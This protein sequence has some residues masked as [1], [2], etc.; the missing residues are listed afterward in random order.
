M[1]A[2][3]GEPGQRLRGLAVGVQLRRR[4]AAPGRPL[5]R[6]D[7]AA[8][9]RPAR[10]P[11][12]RVAALQPRVRR[13]AVGP[14]RSTRSP[15]SRRRSAATRATARPRAADPDFDPIRRE[16]GYPGLVRW[17]WSTS[18]PRMAEL[19]AKALTKDGY[20]A[21]FDAGEPLGD[22]PL[23]RRADD[24]KRRRA[25]PLGPA[26]EGHE[27]APCSSRR[28]RTSARSSAASVRRR[29]GSRRRR[30]PPRPS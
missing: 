17:D 25:A 21:D 4:A 10:A 19:V 14:A 22:R 5:G 28:R 27:P 1:L 29:S 12:Q 13:V 7:R 8:R 2:V 24:R 18:A 15:T 3:G 16:P 30:R 11:R 20:E 26:R 6:G 9:G 23:R